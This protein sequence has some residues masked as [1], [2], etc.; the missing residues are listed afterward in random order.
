MRVVVAALFAVFVAGI[1]LIPR[2][3][4]DDWPA[5]AG[6]RPCAPR[7]YP[8]E[9][10]KAGESGITWVKYTTGPD[11]AVVAAEVAKSS[12][13]ARLDEASLQHVRTCRFRAPGFSGTL[14]Y[15]WVLP[16]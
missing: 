5:D 7:V 14:L 2:L 10:L 15:K 12:G 9:F 8:P 6:A 4:Q 16:S 3:A 13:Y 11:G 1:L